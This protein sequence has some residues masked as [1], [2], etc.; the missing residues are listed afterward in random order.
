MERAAF[1]R[2]NL[3]VAKKPVDEPLTEAEKASTSILNVQVLWFCFLPC[4]CSITRTARSSRNSVLMYNRDLYLLRC[5]VK[6][7]LCMFQEIFHER[8]YKYTYYR[9]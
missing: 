8:V 2:A 5:V 4:A 9:S 3:S 7:E 1:R 6:V